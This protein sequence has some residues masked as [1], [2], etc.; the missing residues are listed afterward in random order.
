MVTPKSMSTAMNARL[1]GSGKETIIL[2]HGYGGD[3]SV[4]DKVVPSLAQ[5]HQVLVFDWSFSGAVKDL[6]LFDAVKYSSYDAFADD[7][8]AL[9]EEMNLKSSV[10]VGHSMSGMIGCIASV[11][12]P[13]LFSRLVLVASSPRFIN[14]EDYEGGFEISHVE[15]IF[16]SIESNYDQWATR[17]ASIVVDNNDP[18]SVE[19]IAGTLKRMGY[20]TALPLAKT[21]FLSDHRAILE[22]VTAPCTIIHTARDLAVPDSV[23]I[24]MQNKIK[25]PST[26]EII[27]TTDGHVPQLTAHKLFLDVLDKVLIGH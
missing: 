17:F 2:A 27:A 16:A 11:K 12:R 25:G 8:I 10:F 20:K 4:W 21:V 24:F 22:K 13:D 7:I 9:V 23:P 5:L 3:H 26:I 19:K 14:S 18:P 6:N 15:Q 1:I